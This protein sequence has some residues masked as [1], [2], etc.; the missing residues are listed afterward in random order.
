M[1]VRFKVSSAAAHLVGSL[2]RAPLT[3]WMFVFVVCC[4]G[5][6]LC[7]GLITCSGESYRLCASY[8]V[9]SRYRKNKTALTDLDCWATERWKERKK[10]RKKEKRKKERKKE[11]RKYIV[12]RFNAYWGIKRPLSSLNR[13]KAKWW[14][15]ILC[16]V[17]IFF[18]LAQR[19][20]TGH[21]LLILEVYRSYTTT[22]HSR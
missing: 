11:R 20:N 4:V 16:I 14:V 9:W 3:V 10:E 8:C 6:G 2:V 5:S 18:S 22:H 13:N 17:L 12:I 1:V 7:D 19:P 21:G 15:V